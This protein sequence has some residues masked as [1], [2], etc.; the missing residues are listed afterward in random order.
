MAE[1]RPNPPARGDA[2]V[3]QALDAAGVPPGPV[4]ER[5]AALIAQRDAAATANAAKSEFLAKMSHEIRTP[6]NGVLGMAEL[7]GVTDLT[8]AQRRSLETIQRSA[9]SLLTIIDDILDFSKIEAGH[10]ELEDVPFDPVTVVDETLELLA[11][12]AHKNGIELLADLD[13]DLPVAVRGDPNRFRQVLTN[14]CG[15][16]I[17]FTSIGH[18]VCRITIPTPGTLRVEVEDTGIGL[19][20]DDRQRI[21]APF[22]QA[23]SSHARRYGGTGLGLAIT[24]QLVGM[25]GGHLQVASTP[26]K[27]SRFWFDWRPA[28]WTAASGDDRPLAGSGVELG[29]VVGHDPFATAL[30]NRLAALGAAAARLVPEQLEGWIGVGVCDRQCHRLTLVDARLGH[31]AVQHIA[32]VAQDGLR[33][34]RPRL[35]LMTDRHLLAEIP[36]G[37]D[38]AIAKPVTS[39]DLI[40]VVERAVGRVFERVRFNDSEVRPR[41]PRQPSR[42][43]GRVLL[44]EDNRVNQEVARGMLSML[45]VDVH[46]VDDGARALEAIQQ[47]RF[48]VVLMDCHMPE[49]NGFEATERIRAGEREAGAPRLPILAVTAS[50]TVD[51]AARCMAAGMDGILGKPFKVVQLHAALLRWLDPAEPQHTTPVGSDTDAPAPIRDP[52]WELFL[53][54]GAQTLKELRAASC[55]GERDSAVHAARQLARDAQ[56]VGEERFVRTCLGFATRALDLGVE[57]LPDA[58]GQLAESFEQLARTGPTATSGSA[59]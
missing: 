2:A 57:E 19:D 17:K 32:R 11:D 42:L 24:R 12:R 54:D 22:T 40:E 50:A 28:G 31:D 34:C 35:V 25:M 13:P 6:M 59:G 53:T 14:L 36:A 9:D 45:G 41:L 16:A 4:A 37:Y 8:V 26:G 3:H 48:D 30:D 47:E 46:C 15:N 38:E 44:A 1:G 29:I 55:R 5:V 52:L 43:S 21:F 58:A 20:A 49:V 23:A 33:F 7:L 56:V 10:L 51:D 39:N 18:V 27:G